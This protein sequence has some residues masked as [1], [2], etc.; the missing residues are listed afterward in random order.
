MLKTEKEIANFIQNDDFMLR[1]LMV[2][3]SANLPNW[4]VGAG[5]VRSTVW[6]IQSGFELK[7]DYKDLDLAYFDAEHVSEGDD[8]LLSGKLNSLLDAN[9]E[10]V[11][12]A[13][14][15]K[16]N[17]VPKYTS[18]IDGL[19][20]WVETATCIAATL[21][22]HDRVQIVA[23]WGV[24]DLLNMKLRLVP[25]FES[26]PYYQKLFMERVKSKCWLERW[27]NLELIAPS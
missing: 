23:P 15:H 11:N 6:D 22:S 9:W 17:D 3:K 18:A 13:Y 27:P 7:Y 19:A 12:Q 16:Y 4:F 25:Y 26:K 2:A 8:E 24:K 14:A 10:V 1:A 21:D 5:F 20:H